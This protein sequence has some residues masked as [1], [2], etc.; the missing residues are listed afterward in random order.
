MIE[1]EG[2]VFRPPSEAYSLIVQVTIGC[3]HNKCTFC[4]MYKEKQFRVRRLEEVK[5]DFD[6]A[7]KAYRRVERIFLADG[8]A[9]MC[10]AAHMAEILR[11]IRQVFPE[12]ERVTS[13]GSP[14][15]ILVKSPEEL[16]Q[17]HDLGL[18]MIYMGLES[19]ADEV[20]TRINKGETADEIV[21][22]GCM[23][24]EAGM[25]LSVTCIAGLG[26][27]ELSEV[28]AVETAHALSRMK[29]EY[30]GL[31]TLLFE[32]PTPL[33]EDWKA[34]RFYLMNPIEIA[35]ETLVLLEHID[36]EGSVFRAN[37][38]SN[39]VNLAG[40]LNRD[41][42]A[43]CEKLRAALAGKVRFRSEAFRAR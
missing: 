13:Y 24:R 19:G 31:L 8:D 34:G 43:M 12:C 41:R 26:S 40:T 32:L 27:T 42:E 5:R 25:K 38:A 22:A 36:C 14:A 33:M 6:A 37:H 30:I 9:L 39:Y 15:S 20:L 35:Q 28:H 2:R 29:P 1:Y 4:D 10:Q 18:E 3:S 16:R 17:L 23:V 21:R 7:R 11:Y